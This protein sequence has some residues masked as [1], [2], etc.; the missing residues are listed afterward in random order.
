VAHFGWFAHF[1]AMDNPTSSA[2]TRELTGWEPR[3]AGLLADLESA[4]YFG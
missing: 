4:G 3:E 2:R 1:A